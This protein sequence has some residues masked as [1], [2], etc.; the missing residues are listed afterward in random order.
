MKLNLRWTL[1]V[2]LAVVGALLLGGIAVSGT[3][4]T[5]DVAA[6]WVSQRGREFMPGHVTIQRGETLNIVNDDGD[7]THHAYVDTPAF[8]FDSSDQQPGKSVQIRFTRSGEFNV[9]CGIHPKMRL[10]V[11]VK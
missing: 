9:L 4:Q 2:A 1:G 11:I 10:N 5:S 6:T 8:S 3:N 7:F